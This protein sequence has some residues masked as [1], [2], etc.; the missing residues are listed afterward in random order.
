[1]KL[2]RSTVDLSKGCVPR[3]VRFDEAQVYAE[4]RNCDTMTTRSKPEIVVPAETR[5]SPSRKGARRSHE[6]E[7]TNE[8]FLQENRAEDTSSSSARSVNRL[9][10][11]SRDWLPI[12][13]EGRRNQA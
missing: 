8:I 3:K 11:E 6:V 1:V 10:I 7:E 13:V 4:E 9:S 2:E 12:F 5:K